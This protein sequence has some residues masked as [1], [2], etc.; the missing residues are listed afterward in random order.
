MAEKVKHLGLERDY[1]KYLYFI[2]KDGSIAR[3]GKAGESPSE[4][5]VPHAVQREKGYLYFID[6][7]GDLARSE[8]SARRKK[9]FDEN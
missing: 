5:L 2:D 1:S 4:V 6:K 8:R 7:E 3:K 9:A